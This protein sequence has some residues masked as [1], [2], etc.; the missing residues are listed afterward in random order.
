DL[1]GVAQVRL[2]L[3]VVDVAHRPALDELAVLR[4]A[5]QPLDFDAA[6]LRHLVAGDDAFQ[7]PPARG[8]FGL[9]AC[10][11]CGFGVRHYL[12]LPFA[13]AALLASGFFASGFLLASATCGFAGV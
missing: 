12:P 10:H 5:D 6:G 3:L 11:R 4:V 9:R 8:L 2:V 1:H 7:E 13:A